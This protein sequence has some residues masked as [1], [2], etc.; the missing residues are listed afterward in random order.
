[1]YDGGNVA[2]WYAGTWFPAMARTLDVPNTAAGPSAL[3]PL[4]ATGLV[5]FSYQ[6]TAIQTWL[7]GQPTADNWR[8]WPAP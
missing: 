8:T 3:K 6:S 4:M 7:K 1:M 2:G 5:D